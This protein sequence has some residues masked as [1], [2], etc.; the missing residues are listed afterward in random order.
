MYR[1]LLAIALSLTLVMALV[2]VPAFAQK[3]PPP[4]KTADCSP[5]Y[6]KNHPNTWDDGICCEGDALTPGTDCNEIYTAL[7]AQG[8]SSGAIRAAA[9]GFLNGSCFVTAEASP[10][11]DD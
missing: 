3:G 9:S 5:G 1:L 2:A 11:T 10:C 4:K 8:A 6:Y 7:T